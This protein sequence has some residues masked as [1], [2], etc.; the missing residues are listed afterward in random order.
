MDKLIKVFIL[1]TSV[2][3]CAC[4]G[5]S[6]PSP[7]TPV[8]VKPPVEAP[9]EPEEPPKSYYSEVT[10]LYENNSYYSLNQF[11]EYKGELVPK[12]SGNLTLY[13]AKH[14]PTA[15]EDWFTYSD[16]EGVGMNIYLSDMQGNSTL[17]TNILTNDPHQ[18]ATILEDDQGMIHV[19][20][21]ARGTIKAGEYYIV[22]PTNMSVGFVKEHYMAYPQPY[23]YNGEVGVVFTKYEQSTRLLYVDAPQCGVVPI[24]N[25]KGH[26][27]MSYMEDGILYVV[28]NTH[29][30]D[31]S[32]N[33]REDLTLVVSEDGGCTW[34]EP[35]LL[36][37]SEGDNI[38]LKSLEVVDG[39]PNV[40]YVR[41]ETYEPTV[42]TKQLFHYNGES[43]ELVSSV[44]HNYASG[45]ACG[46]VIVTPI[47]LDPTKA[48]GSLHTFSK[49]NGEW[50][51][52]GVEEGDYNYAKKS[53]YSES[54]NG[55]VADQ[56]GIYRLEVSYE[57]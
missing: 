2:S 43:V 20:V 34:S 55:V 1:G 41:A 31:N 45:Y 13:T 48:E 6:T 32:S 5:G 28:Y 51:L 17:V 52:T 16:D 38:Y 12:Y 37:D 46:D 24:E 11:T 22:D 57:N 26:Y 27:A 3:L 40:L 14:Q 15:L 44:H 30:K 56:N 4:G 9:V 8:V 25:T 21:A 29:T 39:R 47:S 42:G 33:Q 10:Y 35:E 23:N 18:N 36:V 54:C 53:Q 50:V 7:T 19:I 49:Q